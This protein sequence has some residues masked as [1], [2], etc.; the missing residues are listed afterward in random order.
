MLMITT[1]LVA[2]PLGNPS[3]EFQKYHT[4]KPYMFTN[5]RL[6]IQCHCFQGKIYLEFHMGIQ[7]SANILLYS[8]SKTLFSPKN[9]N[10][11]SFYFLKHFY[12]K[13]WAVMI[14]GNTYHSNRVKQ[15]NKFEEKF[16]VNIE[17]YCLF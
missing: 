11:F 14:K 4:I 7:A 1:H 15:Q 17:H 6:L 3:L 9:V 12:S 10:S 16:Y 8:Y 5:V 2:K 13:S